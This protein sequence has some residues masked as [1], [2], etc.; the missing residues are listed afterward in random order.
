MAPVKYAGRAEPP[1]DRDRRHPLR[2]EVAE[3][4]YV[5]LG[6]GR[7]GTEVDVLDAE[8]GVGLSHPHESVRIFDRIDRAALRGL[9]DR[10]V[11]ASERVAVAAQ[12]VELVREHSR[13]SGTMRLQASAYWATIRRVF[14]SPL[15]PITIG[16][17]GDCTGGGTQIVSASW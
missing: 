13:R 4:A 12:H 17:R 1:S 3:R 16:G 9:L 5:P 8:R 2:V 15:P 10:V 6:I 14:C 11:V 7:G